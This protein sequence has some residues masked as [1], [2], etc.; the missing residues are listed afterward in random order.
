MLVLLLS[1]LKASV[2]KILQMKCFGVFKKGDMYLGLQAHTSMPIKILFQFRRRVSIVLLLVSDFF[3]E[4]ILQ[5]LS[6]ES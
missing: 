3:L 6:Q 5:P 1:M 4:L 2:F